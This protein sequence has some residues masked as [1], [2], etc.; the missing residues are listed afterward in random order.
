MSGDALSVLRDLNAKFIN[1]FVMSDV[2]AHEPII[3]DRFVCIMPNGECFTRK[4]YMTYWAIAFNPT[5][6][7][8]YDYRDER[9][10]IFGNVALVCATTKWIRM[11]DGAETTGMTFYTD[12]YLQEDGIWQCIQAQLT[13]VQPEHYPADDTI[14]KVYI[15]GRLQKQPGAAAAE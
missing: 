8:Y 4:Q 14:L 2:A 5:V 10:S 11:K 3:H 9:I 12:T 13:G 6:T 7:S 1:N 15:G